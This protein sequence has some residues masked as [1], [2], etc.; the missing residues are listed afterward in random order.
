MKILKYVFGGKVLR[1]RVFPVTTK[2]VFVFVIFVLS[3]NLV[4]NYINLTYNRAEMVNL[5]NQL[6]IK[7]LKDIFSFCNNQYE[8]YQY[9]KDIKGSVESI[10]NKGK[11]EF[12]KNKSILLGV[13][14]GGG[15]MF[16]ASKFNKQETFP[17]AKTLSLLNSNKEKYIEE[18]SIYFRFNNKEY[19]GIYKFNQNGIFSS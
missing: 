1:T 17:D 10:E 7:D 12:K 11:Y 15:F 6:L 19:F 2:I 14:P 8:I 13:K 16:Q 4:S 5:M 9:T 18:G 3:S